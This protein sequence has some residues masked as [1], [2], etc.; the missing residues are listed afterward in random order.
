MNDLLKI[1]LGLLL[2][3]LLSCGDDGSSSVSLEDPLA[4]E[5]HEG[6]VFVESR[7]MSVILGS[8]DENANVK[9]SPEMTVKLDYSFFMDRHEVTCKSYNELVEKKRRRECDGD[10]LPVTNVTYYDAVLFANARSKAKNLDTAYT[11]SSAEFDLSGNCILLENLDYHPER[12]SYRL[13]SEAEWVFAARRGWNVKA[14]WNGENSDTRLHKVCEKSVNDFGLCDMEGNAKEWTGDWL[15]YFKDSVLTNFMG[16]SDGGNLGERVV[17]GGS[18]RDAPGAIKIYRRGDTYAVTS[19]TKANYVGFRLVYGPVLDPAWMN[20][21]GAVSENEFF[22]ESSD[23]DVFEKTGSYQT[24]LV[25]RNDINGNLVFVDFNDVRPVATEIVDS[26]DCYHPDISPDGTKIAFCTGM[27]GIQKKS[28][29]YVRN[30]N[31]MGAGLVKLDVESAAIPRWRVLE[32]GDT[33]IVY[34]DDAGDNSDMST[35]NAAGTWQ[36]PFSNGKFGKPQKIMEGAFHGGISADGRLA[37]TGSKKL[38]ARLNDKDEV[39]YN[40]EQACNVSLSKDGSG[41]TLFLDFGSET[42][43]KFVGNRY[44]TH[45]RILVVDSVGKLVQTVAAPKGFVFDHSEWVGG[46]LAV[47]SLSNSNGAHKKLAIVDMA[48][49]SITTLV[50]G[51]ELWHPCLWVGPRKL[52]VEGVDNDSLGAYLFAGATD[53]MKILRYRMENYWRN[54]DS[55][56][57]VVLGTSRSSNGIDSAYFSEK[58]KVMNLSYFWSC[59][60]DTKNFFDRYIDG[61]VPRLKYLIV[62]LD[63][64]I[65]YFQEPENFFYQEYKTVPG[66]AYDENHGYWK[67]KDAFKIYES[68][69]NGRRDPAYEGFGSNR[70]TEFAKSS[71]W[72]ENPEVVYDSMWM[73]SLASRFKMQMEGLKEMACKGRENGFYVVAVIFPISPGFAKTG[74]F[75]RY[76]L[77]RSLVPSI[78]DTL[79]SWQKEI[80]SLVV[81]DENKMG[82]HDYTDDM[83]QDCDHLNRKG[84]A[85]LTTRLN[86]LLKNL[87]N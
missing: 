76:G 30:L 62:S 61:T 6:M 48:D 8:N 13:P 86:A 43:R 40:G 7:G 52:S 69:K 15:G 22:V 18:F 35:F 24:K 68:T 78:M 3:S 82:A 59:L 83:V 29:L 23:E 16:A 63:L 66:F 64:D 38:R 74:A 21:E 57:V 55:A 73:E 85:Q 19:S 84:A 65:I 71:G 10:S 36:V 56:N 28:S 31:G 25:F 42:G 79:K 5:K 70:S 41:R 87:K 34:V 14:G 1:L 2:F 45:Q 37:V 47:T 9:E 17:K 72:S 46:N 77:Q 67:D 20:E 33:V 51:E 12:A 49:S 53:R 44:A 54:R 75:G 58:F 32:N 60:T 26:L 11:Y 80:P 27:E 4:L 50:S 39:W 81:F